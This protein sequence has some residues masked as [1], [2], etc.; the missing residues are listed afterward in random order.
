MVKE[1]VILAAGMGSRLGNQ[2]D[3]KPK[4]FLQLGNQPIIEES[5][6]K[7]IKSAPRARLS[8]SSSD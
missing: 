3:Q 7:L 2:N 8:R 5:I 6:K 4:G 1:A